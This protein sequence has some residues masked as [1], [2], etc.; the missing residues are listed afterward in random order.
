MNYIQ[1]EIMTLRASTAESSPS[2][3]SRKKIGFEYPFS[4]TW[5][6]ACYVLAALT[7]FFAIYFL[8]D[9]DPVELFAIP[10]H[11][12]FFYFMF[13]FALTLIIFK[14][15]LHVYSRAE[16]KEPYESNLIEVEEKSVNLFKQW[17]F[18]LLLVLTFAAFLTPIILSYFLGPLWSFIAIAGFVPA[19]TISEIIVFFYS[20]KSQHEK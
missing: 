12:I 10:I 15:K 7:I 8:W 6:Y 20:Q 3:G 16:E 9:A 11:P 1:H 5:V 2:S 13:T 19:V 17:T 14:L 4:K 18:I